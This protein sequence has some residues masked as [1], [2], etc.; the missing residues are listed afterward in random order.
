MTSQAW[1][2]KGGHLIDPASG[3]DGPGD[4]LVAGGRIVHVGEI[5]RRALQEHAD[6]QVLDATGLL[7]LP[8]LV[9]LRAHM[10]EPGHDSEETVAHGAEVALHGG[11][12]T[13]ACLPDTDPAIDNVGAALFIRRQSEQAGFADVHPVCAVTRGREGRELT[14]IGQLVE[15]GAVAFSDEQRDRDTPGTVLR[16]M[17][18]VAMFDRAFIEGAQDPELAGGVMN[19]GR[20]AMLAGM[21][22]IPA[23]A[24]EL[25]IARACMFARETGCHYHAPTLSTRNAVRA[26]KRAK[27]MGVRVTAE[28]AAHHLVFDDTWVRREY[29]TSFK[30]F[31]PFRTPDD[32]AWLIRGIREGVVDCIV[33]DHM[34]VPPQDKELEFGLAPFGTVGLET[35]LSAAWTSL[36][37]P[38]HISPAALAA[39]LTV[40]PA[41]VL[42]LE[43]KGTLAAGADADLCLFDPA[44]EWHVQA[45]DFFSRARNSPFIGTRLTGRV[46]YT[47]IRGR[48][49]EVFA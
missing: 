41:R 10:G 8:G 11:F 33:S 6:A 45:G 32:R 27:R 47:V 42:R 3:K 22:G 44:C 36:V 9:D 39:M 29:D 49:V 18:Y 37:A 48:L 43:H 30:V 20:E 35:T 1:I 19:A 16:G 46:R 26:V 15:A 23:V 13:V 4:V 24:E 34:P 7:V 28:V 40:N 5:P 12:T 25:A 2:I 14:E 17:Q 31:P 38:G 21:P